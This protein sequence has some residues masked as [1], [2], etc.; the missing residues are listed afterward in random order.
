[1][2]RRTAV[3]L[4]LGVALA[5]AAAWATVQF[6]RIRAQTPIEHLA[7]LRVA[8]LVAP[9]RY[10]ELG[11]LG[12][13]YGIAAG[14][15]AFVRSPH[16]LVEITPGGAASR[17]DPQGSP[18]IDSLAIGADNS[19]LTVAD[20]FLGTLG[21]DGVPVAGVPLPYA[22][23]RLA[24]SAAP[25]SVYLFGPSSTGHRLYRFFEDGKYRILLQADAPIRAV[26]DTRDSLF[27]ASD[28]AVV[29]LSTEGQ[30]LVFRLPEDA[31]PGPIVSI[32]ARDD[33]LL[34]V[35]T[36]SRVFAVIGGEAL[37]IVNDSGG[38]LRLSGESLFVLDDK[39]GLF[40]RLA[41]ATQ[42]MFEGTG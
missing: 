7:S 19:L 9:E 26:S 31:D 25:G 16:G 11:P 40:Y 36:A 35:A 29:R 39:R 5:G 1:M 8:Y 17:V 14:G 15:D 33:K 22:G 12:P 23:A 30:T 42:R 34:F 37:S 20:G 13:D 38:Q 6:L 3:L 4:A 2:K 10:A 27:I 28:R 21:D 18:K 32:A 24:P 41:P